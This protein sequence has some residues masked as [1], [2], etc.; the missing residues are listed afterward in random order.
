MNKIVLFII[1]FST[2]LMADSLNVSKM[3]NIDN[4][5]K[6]A[7][8]ISFGTHSIKCEFTQQKHL[9]FISE[10]IIS[11]GVFC[12]KKENLLR[13]EYNDPFEYIIV[14]NDSEIFIKD[15]NS[16]ELHGIQAGF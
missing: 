14:I 2:S 7:K 10:T 6:L 11:K 15:N 3:K 12:Y 16:I 13:W 1:I 9:S 8:E 4:F 5:V